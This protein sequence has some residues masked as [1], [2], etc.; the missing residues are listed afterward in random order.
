MSKK[1]SSKLDLDFSEIGENVPKPKSIK[2]NKSKNK[3]K[4]LKTKLGD[5]VL[6]IPTEGSNPTFISKTIANCTS[7]EFTKWAKKVAYPLDPNPEYFSEE[8]NRISQFLKILTFHKRNFT[9]SNP[10][11]AQTLH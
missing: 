3:N 8:E 7:T 9:V 6:S 4:N 11:A 1:D 2:N 10:N 5:I